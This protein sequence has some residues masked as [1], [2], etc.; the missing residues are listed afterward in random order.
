MGKETW[1]VV[2]RAAGSFVHNIFVVEEMSDQKEVRK[3]TKHAWLGLRQGG[4][5]LTSAALS[6]PAAQLSAKVDFMG[7]LANQ[8]EFAKLSTQNDLGFR[9]GQMMGEGYAFCLRWSENS[10]GQ[11]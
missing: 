2:D 9:R 4:L 6:A 10:T 8:D 3:G 5:R 11:S 7:W 1:L